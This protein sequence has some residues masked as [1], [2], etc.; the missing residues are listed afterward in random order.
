MDDQPFRAGL[1]SVRVKRRLRQVDLAAMVG[2]S[3]ALI[4]RLERGHLDGV[5]V[6]T[7]RLL[8]RQLD[9]PADLA[10]PRPA[11]APGRARRAAERVGGGAPRRS[12]RPGSTLAGR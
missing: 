12:R 4:S 1:R 6:A 10:G 11:R 7:I 5:T 8:A 9:V 2:V 3:D